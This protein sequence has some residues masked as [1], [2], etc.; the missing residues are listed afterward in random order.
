MLR[1]KQLKRF[2]PL[3]LG[4]LLMICCL[5]SSALAQQPGIRIA[6]ARVLT[7]Q[8]A[9]MLMEQQMME[10]G[11]MPVEAGAGPASMD[12]A[13]DAEVSE[14]DAAMEARLATLAELTFDRLPSTILERW[15]NAELI[16]DE[17]EREQLADLPPAPVNAFLYNDD[18][19]KLATLK[20]QRD[21]TLG[22]WD[23]VSSFL[24]MLPGKHASSLY[25]QMLNALAG[26]G[27]EVLGANQ[28]DPGDD[29][30]TLQ[31][32]TITTDDFFRF[33]AIA[34]EE[35]EDAEI[36]SYARVMQS[37]LNRGNDVQEFLERFRTG[38]ESE[39][40]AFSLRQ[41]AKLLM[42]AGQS[43]HVLEFIPDIDTAATDNDHEALNLLSRH[44][45][46]KYSEDNKREYLES[47]WL[48][49]QK[50]L[51]A[52]GVDPDE[53]KEA[54][55][56][57]VQMS[58]QVSEEQ[59]IAWL[60]ESFIERPERGVEVIAAIGS[61]T[62]RSLSQH[63]R[64]SD[65]RL[66][67]LELQNK[68]V[69]ALLE[70]A[71]DSENG[72]EVLDDP[73]WQS[74]LS[75]LA[76][77]WLRE[78]EI[79][80]TDDDSTS[81]G[82]S[83]NRDMYGNYFFMEMQM[84]RQR[85]SYGIDPVPVAKLLKIVPA[86]EW[87]RFVESGMHPRFDE[88]LAKLYL[89]VGE[90]AQALP[91]IEGLAETHPDQV[92]SLVDKFLEI[93]TSN[94]DPNSESR[95]N[96]YFGYMYG[97]ESRAESIPLTRSK[98]ERN[99]AELEELIP[100]L[101]AIS[102]DE[103]DQELVLNAFF[104][105]HSVAEVYREED[106]EQVFGSIE[107]V[108]PDVIRELAQRMQSNLATIW[109][110]ADVQKDNKT[111][112]TKKEIQD[113][114]FRGYE[115]ARIVVADAL[116]RHPQNWALTC[117]Q[118]ALEH[119]EN[120][121]RAELENSVEFTENRQSALD[122][123]AS[124]ASKYVRELAELEEDDYSTVSFVT[125]FYASL[126]ACEPGMIEE[127]H[128]SASAEFERIRETLL[129]IEDD[130]QREWHMSRF[131]NL[132]FQRMSGIKPELKTR[133]LDG[134]FVVV[135]DHEDA[136]DAREVHEYY[137]D[138]VTEIK[139][140][141]VID[142]SDRVGTRPFGMFVNL[143]HTREIERES[144]GFG[145]YLQNQNNQGF[146]AY[147]YGRPTEDYRDKFEESTRKL[148][149][150]HFEVHSITFHKPSV[151]SVPSTEFG[152]RVTPYA[153]VLLEAK[154]P[155]VDKVPPLKINLDFLDTSGYAILPIE[156]ATVLISPD[157]VSDRPYD[158]LTVTEILDERQA[159]DGKLLLE[160]KATAQGLV[161]DLEQI[162]SVDSG[163]FEI[164][165]IDDPG[166]S[167]TSFDEEADGNVIMSE[168]T[169]VVSYE[170]KES[171]TERPEE[172]SFPV[173]DIEVTEVA[174]QRYDDADLVNVESTISLEERYAKTNYWILGLIAAGGLA[175]IGAMIGLFV[176]ISRPQTQQSAGGI[177]VEDNPSPFKAISL[178]EDI[179]D[180]NGLSEDGK[181]QLGETI[182]RLERYYFGDETE[183]HDTA[184]PD[185][186]AEL[187]KWLSSRN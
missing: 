63:M 149:G 38:I 155:E 187:R 79:S 178:L 181:H 182:N 32:Q 154:G 99:L 121:Y 93:W 92:E 112:R 20:L 119:D 21:F 161:P 160:I 118:A 159:A 43:E 111:R 48:A 126:G 145:R 52:E 41:V 89:K 22:N 172:F 151:Q 46:I 179:R 169:W 45:R 135:G 104:T 16:E 9:Q 58:T 76:W 69:K 100:R 25:K 23:E 39:E 90:E 78:A 74:A 110:D 168:R 170:A 176:V 146:Y 2:F 54:L 40:S 147:N 5:Q 130:D 180:N 164:T 84:N 6:P 12:G 96:D 29:P 49:T 64:D 66:E 56:R 116:A 150:E 1:P 47:A 14:R 141:T 134:G 108:E 166:V 37:L 109:R 30:R 53:R 36:A 81:T 122:K 105:C 152:W 97:Y 75:L 88:V 17:E 65:H 128:I 131:A 117:A 80:F 7:P 57:A 33:A 124:A 127:K 165:E 107:N 95:R 51:A 167:V 8:E 61:D 115:A 177:Q 106:I 138:L 148:L 184:E 26:T 68:A 183:R 67:L 136:A 174:Y 35:L 102:G 144:G 31:G 162:M 114:V 156:S 60:N 72:I 137:R 50:V 157:D 34:P 4:S 132:L 171:L 123:F 28:M 163:K 71:A 11:A 185:L 153:Y 175:L 142:G 77:N 139:L 120:N 125:W 24:S 70:I 15:N 27:V 87:M 91:Y 103:L 98:Q 83:V 42:G 173:P 113:E 13:D 143:L 3:A 10:A 86:A 62:A 186:S 133:Y 44:Y 101:R 94:H 82:P 55:K 73:A 158:Q 85:R 18:F 19:F 129:S 59:G 140:E